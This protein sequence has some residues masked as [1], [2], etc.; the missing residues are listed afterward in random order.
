MPSLMQTMAASPRVFATEK[1]NAKVKPSLIVVDNVNAAADAVIGIVDRFTP[2]VTNGVPIPAVQT[3]TRLQI[4]VSIN[5]CVSLRDE[6][7]DVE[8]LGQLEV[9]RGTLLAPVVDANCFV[10]VAYDYE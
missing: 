2:A 10:T 7:K 4:N 9:V 1:R 8:I 3:P 6:L 5:A